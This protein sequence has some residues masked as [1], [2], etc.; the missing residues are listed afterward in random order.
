[1]SDHAGRRSR[2]CRA[3]WGHQATC[4]REAPPVALRR[5]PSN[6]SP[7]PPPRPP[8]RT[9]Q[10]LRPQ[11]AGPTPGRRTRPV[12]TAQGRHRVPS[13]DQP[14]PPRDR[15]RPPRLR[16]RT[17]RHFETLRVTRCA[18]A[19][20]RGGRRRVRPRTAAR[21]CARPRLGCAPHGRGQDDVVRSHTVR[22]RC[23]RSGTASVRAGA[24]RSSARTPPA[25]R[26]S[27]DVQ[28][29]SATSGRSVPCSRIHAWWRARTSTIC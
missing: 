1:M 19:A 8:H 5:P 9:P 29:Q 21:T 14:Q 28:L 13:R 26:G 15:R 12:R 23:S 27:Q 6:S 17:R 25:R 18:P 22:T 16:R 11:A 10:R 20:P 4:R 2:T 7:R 24:C 3:L